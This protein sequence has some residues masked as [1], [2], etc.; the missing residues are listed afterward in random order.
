[1][2]Y[3]SMRMDRIEAGDGVCKNHALHLGSQSIGQEPAAMNLGYRRLGGLLQR[4]MRRWPDVPF[5]A[6][7]RR[8]HDQVIGPSSFPPTRRPPTP[9]SARSG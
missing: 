9:G 8:L 1:M 2:G 6:A 4:G 7:E 3:A 5:K